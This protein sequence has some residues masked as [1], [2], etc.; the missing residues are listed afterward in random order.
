LAKFAE[1][2]AAQLTSADSQILVDLHD[3]VDWRTQAQGTTFTPHEVDDVAIRSYLLH[4]KFSGATRL[5]LERTIASLKRFYDWVRTN[6]LIAKSPF[7]SFDFN[8]PLLSP[9][10][11]K[12]REEARFA[13]PT[14]REIAHLRALN[15]LAE[16]L[17]RSVDVRTL[18][19][20][21]VQTLVQAMGLNTAWAFLWTEAGLYTTTSANHPPH[22]FALAACCG[23]PP[24]L[25][26]TIDAICVSRPI[27]TA[28]V[29]YETTN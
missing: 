23:L 24:G 27:I 26:R 22:D 14:D 7:D 9:E 20:T 19:A 17:N 4:L 15:H 6:H 18:L 1:Q 11:I 13:N 16:H 25:G 28:R 8:R 10:Q 21:V 2:F 5:I 12:R 3:F 29:C